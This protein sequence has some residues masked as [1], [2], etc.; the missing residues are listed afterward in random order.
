MDHTN[1]KKCRKCGEVKLFSDMRQHVARKNGCLN[2]CK[3]CDAKMKM[4]YYNK[5]KDRRKEL[6]N[7]R[8]TTKKLF[9][10]LPFHKLDDFN[11]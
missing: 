7:A 10:K 5:T 6:N 11:E 3:K 8:Y 4:D 1:S 9:K 2:V